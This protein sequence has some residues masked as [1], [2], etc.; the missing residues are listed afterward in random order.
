MTDHILNFAISIDDSAI[1]KNIQEKAEQQII[2]DI[3]EDLIRRIFED[4]WNGR[5]S[6]VRKNYDGSISVTHSAN[7]KD[8]TIQLVKDTL[9]EFK[10]EIIAAAA[11]E[12][13]DSYKRTKKWKE[14]TEEVMK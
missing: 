3:K 13:A 10:D 8:P 14:L 5:S 1:I 9:L 2:N 4:G 12:L 6:P 11:K 7:L